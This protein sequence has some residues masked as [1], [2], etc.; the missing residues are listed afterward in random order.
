MGQAGPRPA[1]RN[2]AAKLER[3]SRLY[4]Q[5][6]SVGALPALYA[7]TLPDAPGGSCFGP[8]HLGETR[9]APAPAR[10]PKHA[11]DALMAQALW[12]ESARP[13]GLEA[14]AE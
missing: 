5:P 4:T 7:A 12:D 1:G 8:A 11:Q 3:T 10:K 14:D 9:G 2:W 13:A 6:A